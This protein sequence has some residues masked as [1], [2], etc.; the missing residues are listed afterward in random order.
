MLVFYIVYVA[1]KLAQAKDED[2]VLDENIMKD[3][4]IKIDDIQT[5]RETVLSKAGILLTSLAR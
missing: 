2:A 5:Y 1:N 3:S 4:N